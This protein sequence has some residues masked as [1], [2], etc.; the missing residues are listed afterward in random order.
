MLRDT[1]QEQFK[2]RAAW[3][4]GNFL[5]HLPPV[6]F[7]AVNRPFYERSRFG[8]GWCF[9]A[10][11]IYRDDAGQLCRANT[12]CGHHPDI[13]SH[14][15]DTVVEYWGRSGRVCISDEPAQRCDQELKRLTDNRSPH[16]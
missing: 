9:N 15:W 2:R 11:Y 13:L 10:S 14:M 3:D 4:A 6:M 7:I 8:S 12:S 16:R 5:R 1:A